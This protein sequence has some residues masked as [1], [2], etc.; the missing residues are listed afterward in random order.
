M[1]D[2]TPT[3]WGWRDAGNKRGN[4]HTP[5]TDGIDGQYRID[6]VAVSII[7]IERTRVPTKQ[8]MRGVCNNLA[9]VLWSSCPAQFSGQS[10]EGD[11]ESLSSLSLGNVFG[12]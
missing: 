10:G 2:D 5:A 7:E 3:F 11:T 8:P 9:C 6:Q 4:I 1:I 12:N